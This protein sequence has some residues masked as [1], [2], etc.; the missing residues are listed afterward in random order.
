MAFEG[1]RVRLEA[2]PG[3]RWSTV[4]GPREARDLSLGLRK[5]CMSV[6]VAGHLGSAIVS[7][8]FQDCVRSL[9]VTSPLDIY[10]IL[11]TFLGRHPLENGALIPAKDHSRGTVSR[12]T[13]ETSPRVSCCKD[14]DTAQIVSEPFL[15]RAKTLRELEECRHPSNFTFEVTNI[16]VGSYGE[17]ERHVL[18]PPSI[19]I[20]RTPDL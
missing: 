9:A 18:M 4:D 19:Y 13:G 2:A 5:T 11:G 17:L 8:G 6:W 14:H 16:G 20:L 15:P 3:P 12:E 10:M 7:S 1:P